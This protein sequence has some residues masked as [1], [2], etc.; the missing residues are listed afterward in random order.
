MSTGLRELTDADLD[1]ALE[2]VLVPR[3]SGLIST[4]RPGHC[5]RVSD[6]PAAL[7]ARVCRR[8]RG[9][10][11]DVQAHVLGAPPTVPDDV[12]VTGT[13]LVE[14]RNPDP[15]G[16]QR[17]P[18]LVFIPPG[19]HA[20]AED[21]FGVATFEEA[22][23]GDVYADLMTRLL[24]VLPEDLRRGVT[25]LFAVLD[26]QRH[27]DHGSCSPSRSTTTTRR[28]PGPRC[29][30]SASSPTSSCSATPSRSAPGS[31]GTHDMCAPCSAPT[32]R[33]ANG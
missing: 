33:S 26:D 24:P 31:R 30:S 17:P 10:V 3:L 22:D 13:K 28:P 6:V 15:A 29:S 27:D 1:E 11:A 5:V 2:R 19:T 8:V 18:L 12:A 7:A 16:R 23:L 20:S 4:R 25:E 21:S 9:A 32:G 14:L